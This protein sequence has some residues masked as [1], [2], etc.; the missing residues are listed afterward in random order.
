MNTEL[1]SCPFFGGK[2]YCNVPSTENLKYLISRIHF[3][4]DIAM[5]QN[6]SVLIFGAFGCGVFGQDAETV[7]SIAKETFTRT[8]LRKLIHPIPDKHNLTCF[9]SA[10]GLSSL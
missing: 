10:Y 1:K 5:E 4:R 6:I 2:E 7:A 9:E 8:A 3:V